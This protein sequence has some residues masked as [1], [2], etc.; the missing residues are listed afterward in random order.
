MSNVNTVF[1][2]SDAFIEPGQ[3]T[4]LERIIQFLIRAAD[5]NV[6]SNLED[7]DAE[8]QLNKLKDFQ[9]ETEQVISTL[10]GQ[11]LN[12]EQELNSLPEDLSGTINVLIQDVLN[13]KSLVDHLE[14]LL[15]SI[16]LNNLVFLNQAQEVT[17]KT[18]KDS[19]IVESN[20][21]GKEL[22]LDNCSVREVTVPEGKT[23]VIPSG[24]ELKHTMNLTGN[25]VVI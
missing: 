10:E 19:E 12:L 5:D 22:Y 13:L 24:F 7:L 16:D 1:S 17:N 6:R 15:N 21:Y 23:K 25:L 4:E 11:L 20:L 14:S 9:T 2:F 18:I 3:R 8:N